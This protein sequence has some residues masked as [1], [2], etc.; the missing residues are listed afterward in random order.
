[1]RGRTTFPAG[2]SFPASTLLSFL[3][4][5]ALCTGPLFLPR[6]HSYFVEFAPQELKMHSGSQEPFLAHL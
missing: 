1:M 2:G 4:T 6:L 5:G 3:P